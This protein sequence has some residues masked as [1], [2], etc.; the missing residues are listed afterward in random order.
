[1]HIAIETPS[2]RSRS[3]PTPIAAVISL[4]SAVAG[5]VSFVTSGACKQQVDLMCSINSLLAY[6]LLAIGMLLG[7]VAAIVAVCRHEHRFMTLLAFLTTGAML[8]YI[9]Y[10]VFRPAMA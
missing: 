8:L 2:T 3:Q 1:M 5:F 10:S 4:A 6:R 7:F 9:A